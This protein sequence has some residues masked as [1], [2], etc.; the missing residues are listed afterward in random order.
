MDNAAYLLLDELGG[1]IDTWKGDLVPI[2]DLQDGSV[3]S[4]GNPF[5]TRT[6]PGTDVSLN[7]ILGLDSLLNLGQYIRHYLRPRLPD[8][9]TMTSPATR[10]IP[11]GDEEGDDPDTDFY[12]ADGNPTLGG[13]FDYLEANWIPTL[14]GGAGGLS[15]NPIE[16]TTDADGDGDTSEIVGVAVTFTQ[17]F[18]FERT[19]GFDFGEEAESIG[20]TVDGDM[21]LNL[22]V[23]INLELFLSFNWATDEVDFALNDLTFNAHARRMISSWGRV[24]VRCM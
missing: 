24:S 18:P 23:D 6:I 7:R 17:D 22:N 19:V 2:Y 13:F 3:V 16:D 21:E 4:E 20:L 14:G 15:W 1:Q 11:L 9:A 10:A 8:G 12:G 5:L